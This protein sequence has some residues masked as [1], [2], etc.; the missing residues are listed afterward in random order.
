[1]SR[2]RAI[3]ILI[4][5]AGWVLLGV[6]CA[7]YDLIL[8]REVVDPTSGWAAF[9]ERFGSLPGAYVLAV[10][11]SVLFLRAPSASRTPL[12]QAVLWFTSSTC[13]AAAIGASAY[14]LWG[15]RFSLERAL[16][17]FCIVGAVSFSARRAVGAGLQLSPQQARAAHWATLLGVSS[18]LV[19]HVTKVLWGRVRYRDLDEVAATFS[20]WYMPRGFTG[21]E[22]FPSGHTAMGWMLLPCLML[23][24][25][26]TV[27]SRI[28]ASLAIG[29][30]A[31]VAASRVVIGAH[32]ASDVLFS[33]AFA[34]TLCWYAFRENPST[35]EASA[36]QRREPGDRRD[37][38]RPED[39][40]GLTTS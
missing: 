34:A 24:S 22:S 19:V 8:S 15:D 4:V 30:G 7:R 25:R 32:Y 28:A 17:T 2:A 29:W 38:D 26:N 13:V 39:A 35:F 1:M 12:M 20:A 23:W 16:I 33:T 5:T 10:A 21:H 6:L 9:G 31:F 36:L 18:W 40:D 11:S 27:G 14:R 37:P 3:R